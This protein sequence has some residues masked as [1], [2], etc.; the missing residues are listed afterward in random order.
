MPARRVRLRCTYSLGDIVA[1]TGAVRELHQKYPCEFVTAVDTRFPD[2]WRFNPYIQDLGP[3]VHTI[4]CSRVQVDR[5]GGTGQHYI[6]AYLQFINQELG[7][8]A[9]VQKLAGDIYLSEEE[10]GWYSEIYNYCRQEIPYWIVCSGGKFDIPIKWWDHRRFQGV[11]DHFRGRIQFVQVG[12]WGNH[13]P[14]LDLRPHRPATAARR[15][16]RAIFAE[17]PVFAT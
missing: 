13:H 14:R 3:E 2:V 1:L 9:K 6:T 4:D 11:V 16:G 5:T 17:K 7:T 8:E 15:R 12:S 10:K